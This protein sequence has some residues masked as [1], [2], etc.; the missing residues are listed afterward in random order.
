MKGPINPLAPAQ[1]GAA[2]DDDSLHAALL[3]LADDLLILPNRAVADV[4]PA[5]SLEPLS[6]DHAPWLLGY[7]RW[8][9]YK[10]AVIDL[11]HMNTQRAPQTTPRRARVVVLRTGG[12][13]PAGGHVGV[14][15]QGYPHL[16]TLNRQVLHPVELAPEDRA[17]LI[18]ARVQMGHQR[19]L[20]PD[21][22][23]IGNELERL[24]DAL[25]SSA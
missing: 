15:T 18:L 24:G 22:E 1:G 7:C 19:G 5:E 10:V 11:V 14:L 4:L 20:V 9:Q 8:Q 17:E 3:T 12:E 6:L 23:R 16:A 2:P 21:L 25:G 13:Q